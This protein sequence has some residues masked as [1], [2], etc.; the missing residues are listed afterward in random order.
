MRA[1]FFSTFICTPFLKAKLK[2]TFWPSILYF[3]FWKMKNKSWK[4]LVRKKFC[5]YLHT[6]QIFQCFYGPKAKFQTELSTFF[7]DDLPQFCRISIYY[8]KKSSTFFHSLWPQISG[9]VKFTSKLI[10]QE[11][12]NLTWSRVVKCLKSKYS[13]KFTILALNNWFGHKWNV[14]IKCKHCSD[15]HRQYFIYTNIILIIKILYTIFFMKT[16][17]WSQKIHKIFQFPSWNDN[18]KLHHA[19][20]DLKIGLTQI[21]PQENDNFRPSHI[22]F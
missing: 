1:N 3:A 9:H 4:A 16:T 21:W 5:Y 8:Q 12:F 15:N 10:F 20:Y 2:V 14:N 18:L 13:G 11:F 19:R 6:L 7:Y 17:D 22:F